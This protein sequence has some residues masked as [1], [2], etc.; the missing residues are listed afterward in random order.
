M[1]FC[2]EYIITDTGENY[3]TFLVLWVAVSKE[4]RVLSK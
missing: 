1:Y 4:R 2:L 3:L